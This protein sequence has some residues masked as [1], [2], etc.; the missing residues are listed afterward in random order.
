MPLEWKKARRVGGIRGSRLC[1]VGSKPI[2]I[3]EPV[4]KVHLRFFRKNGWSFLK[5]RH[6]G[7]P[8]MM[9]SEDRL[10]Q[11]SMFLPFRYL[12]LIRTDH[13]LFP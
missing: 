7:E 5:Q 11:Y 8:C 9:P 10:S 2:R 6:M 3:D 1:K 13:R 12:C 4:K